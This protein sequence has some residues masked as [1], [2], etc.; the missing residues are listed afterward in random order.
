MG[1]LDHRRTWGYEVAASPADCLRAFAAAFGGKGGFMAKARWSVQVGSDSATATYE[2]RKGIGAAGGILSKTSAQEADTAI[3]SQ[4]SFKVE[5]SG[6]G[7]TRCSM[8]L[9]SSGRSGIAG[10]FGATSD[11]RFIRPYMQAVSS[12]L[13]KLDPQ[14]VIQSS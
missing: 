14:A 3:G 8:W 1:M 10:L 6:E 7:R 11:G 9:A 5:G 4:V 12:E 13:L 2:G